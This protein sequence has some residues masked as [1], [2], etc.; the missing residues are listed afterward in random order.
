MSLK[1]EESREGGGSKKKINIYL[2]SR[3]S[4]GEHYI[5]ITFKIAIKTISV[6]T[7]YFH[8]LFT[9]MDARLSDTFGMSTTHVD[10]KHQ[11]R[12][13]VYLPSRSLLPFSFL[14]E[15]FC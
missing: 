12:V 3:R 15:Y 2:V 10:C 13:R 11:L 6:Q 4:E 8:H 5:L 7:A 14:S 1:N 9:C